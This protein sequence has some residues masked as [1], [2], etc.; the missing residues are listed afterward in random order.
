MDELDELPHTVWVTWEAEDNLGY[1][2]LGE[3]GDGQAAVQKIVPYPRGAG[4]IILDFSEEGVL[5]G[6]EFLGI[7]AMPPSMIPKNVRDKA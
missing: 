4:E 7:D 3:I 1:I 6:I 2:R 5:L